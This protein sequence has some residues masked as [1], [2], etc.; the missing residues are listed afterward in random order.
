MLRL[1]AGRCEQATAPAHDAR[2]I[3]QSRPRRAVAIGKADVRRPGTGRAQ[4]HV[5]DH[6]ARSDATIAFGY[7]RERRAIAKA[8]DR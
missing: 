2:R 5:H 7:W 8:M 6:A 4:R 1:A 3:D